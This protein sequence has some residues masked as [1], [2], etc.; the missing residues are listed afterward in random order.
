M[1]NLDSLLPAGFKEF[2]ADR[3][4][5]LA[6]FEAAEADYNR[7]LAALKPPSNPKETEA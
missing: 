1:S 2:F 6:A 5:R 4:E 7:A 3:P